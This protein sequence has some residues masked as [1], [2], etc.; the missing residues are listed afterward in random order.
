M[1]LFADTALSVAAMAREVEM[2]VVAMVEVVGGPEHGGEYATGA[3]M[4]IAPEIAFGPGLPPTG[5][6]LYDAFGREHESRGRHGVGMAVLGQG[7]PNDVVHGSA[8]VRGRQSKFDDPYPQVI[9]RRWNHHALH[10]TIDRR[11]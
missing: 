5:P 7:G 3:A 6:D 8:R 2:E 1:V 4:H 9:A 10:P 11:H